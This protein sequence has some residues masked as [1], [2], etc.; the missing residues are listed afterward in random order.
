MKFIKNSS[1]RY[2][3]IRICKNLFGNNSIICSYGST[4]SNHGNMKIIECV[5][6]EELKKKLNEITKR[7]LRHGYERVENPKE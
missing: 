1:N 6:E 2:Y 3:H 4:K 5:T 7:R